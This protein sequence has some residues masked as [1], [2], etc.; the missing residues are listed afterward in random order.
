MVK[1]MCTFCRLGSKDILSDHKTQNKIFFNNRIS[2]KL[3][4]RACRKSSDSGFLPGSGP[5]LPRP[6]GPPRLRTRPGKPGDELWEHDPEFEC[7]SIH[8]ERTVYI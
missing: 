8:N 7:N 2:N 6:P 1:L 4:F 3:N 5:G